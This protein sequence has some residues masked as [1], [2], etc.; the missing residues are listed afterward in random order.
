MI[1]SASEQDLDFLGQH[2]GHLNRAR[3]LEKVRRGEVYVVEHDSK[4]IGLARYNLFCDLVPFLTNIHILAPYHRRGFGSQLIQYW[5]QQMK[6]Q[7]HT[8][9]LTS[10]Q[11]DEEA[12][13][14]Y[15]KLGYRDTGAL[16]LPG[17]EATELVLCK[18]P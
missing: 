10:T 11:A 2:D 1:R 7:G 6:A 9:V 15:R 13:F 8:L 4:L 18:T 16:L 12:Q 3:L 5:E 17:Q 14:F